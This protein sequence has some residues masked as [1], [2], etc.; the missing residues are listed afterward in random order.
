MKKKLM[1]A[2]C[3]MTLGLG[4]T[5]SVFAANSKTSKPVATTTKAP[6]TGEA[7]TVAGA[8]A[9]AVAL[10]GVVVVSKKKMAE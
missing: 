8:V 4:M 9:A 1:T 10:G 3:L 5:T 7:N 2:L 6:A